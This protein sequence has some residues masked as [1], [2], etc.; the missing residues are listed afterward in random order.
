MASEI[1]RIVRS[2]DAD[3]WTVSDGRG[4]VLLFC[5]GGPGCSDYLKPV[6]DMVTD[7][8]RIIRFE[9]RGCGRTSFK[10]PYTYAQTDRDIEAIRINYEIES[11][12]LVGHSAG[13][14]MALHYALHYPERV[15]SI[16]GLAAGQIWNDREWS[17]TYHQRLEERGER[18][19]EFHHPSDPAVNVE[20]N[21]YWRMFIQQPELLRDLSKLDV[22]TLLIGAGEDVRPNW[23]QQQLANLVPKGCYVE[24]DGAEHYI[25]LT[26]AAA[27]K[28]VLRNAVLDLVRPSTR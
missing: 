23:P 1:E 2:A 22:P 7:L 10:R 24:I 9:P 6:S 16:I 17:K 19:A 15:E 5:N 14:N 3:I 27:L 25:W 18:K 13:V 21:A 12:C 20:G 11:M 8:R 4:P 28:E 26:H